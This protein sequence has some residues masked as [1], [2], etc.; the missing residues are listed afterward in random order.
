MINIGINDGDLLA[1]HKT[2]VAENGAVVVA[3]IGDEVTVKRLKRGKD[4]RHLQLLP[5]NDRL[6]PINVDLA[7]EEFAIEGLSVGVIRQ[8]V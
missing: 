1:V 2:E 6:G 3:R 8:S 4:R 5:E 7:E